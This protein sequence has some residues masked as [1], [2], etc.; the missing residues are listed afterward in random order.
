MVMDREEY[1]AIVE[2]FNYR[3]QWIRFQ[4][5]RNNLIFEKVSKILSEI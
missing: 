2:N 5:C 4:H 3:I 1:D